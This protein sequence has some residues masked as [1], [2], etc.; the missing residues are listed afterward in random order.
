MTSRFGWTDSQ[1]ALVEPSN[2]KGKSHDVSD[3]ARDESGRWTAGGGGGKK[4][5]A[6]AKKDPAEGR[7]TKPEERHKGK[8]PPVLSMRAPPWPTGKKGDRKAGGFTA[9]GHTNTKLGD[10]AEESLSVLDLRSILPVGVSG[11][12]KRQNPLDREY[13]H[14]GW[15]FEIRRWKT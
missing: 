5:K 13:D 10:L 12:T 2:P 14:S 7:P 11:K 9:T 8:T 3:E 4:V 6:A 1:L 15:A